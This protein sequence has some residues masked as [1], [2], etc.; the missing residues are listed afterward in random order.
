MNG[1]MWLRALC[2]GSGLLGP[3]APIA[4]APTEP[5]PAEVSRL[6]TLP[7][8]GASARDAIGAVQR[9]TGVRIEAHW[10]E[11]ALDPEAS[12]SIPGTPMTA[13]NLVESVLSQ[14]GHGEPGLWQ[15]LEDGTV[16]VGTRAQLGSRLTVRI[17]HIRD[18]LASPPDHGRAPTVD[19]QAALQ[20][21][22]GQSVLRETPD[23][24]ATD[25]EAVDPA[26]DLIRLITELVEPDQWR[27]AGGAATIRIFQGS[28]I[29][30]APG[31]L[32]RQL[33]WTKSDDIHPPR[34][35]SPAK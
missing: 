17:Y 20:A 25:E 4:A 8:S 27:D 11:E 6:F 31:F 33:A 12:V 35:V 24:P 22:R 26:A 16:E 9:A 7:I 3:I 30:S 23:D 1:S 10:G 5:R 18:L 15:A 19:L 28:L 13:R 14:C 2:I 29:V 34:P 21:S 32:H